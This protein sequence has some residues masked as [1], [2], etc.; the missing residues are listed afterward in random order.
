[1]FSAFGAT[2]FDLE[3]MV[4]VDGWLIDLSLSIWGDVVL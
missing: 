2:P 3:A 4:I 1:M